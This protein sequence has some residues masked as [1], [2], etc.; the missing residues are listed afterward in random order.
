MLVSEFYMNPNPWFI[1]PALPHNMKHI[2]VKVVTG[3]RCAKN[4]R[5]QEVFIL[6]LLRLLHMLATGR[7]PPF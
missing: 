7:Q 4:S 3:N 5:E 1:S 2:R 6:M